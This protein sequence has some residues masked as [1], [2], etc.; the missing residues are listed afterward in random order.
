MGRKERHK[1]QEVLQPVLEAEWLQT[2]D[3]AFSPILEDPVDLRH[4]GNT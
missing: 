3:S 4:L 2:V 1:N